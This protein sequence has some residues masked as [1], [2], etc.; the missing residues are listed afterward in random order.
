MIFSYFFQF[1]GLSCKICQRVW[2]SK[3]RSYQC[4]YNNE[5]F[6]WLLGS[7]QWLHGMIHSKDSVFLILHCETHSNHI[8]VVAFNVPQLTQPLFLQ[9]NQTLRNAFL[10]SIML[11][12]HRFSLKLIIS[13][14][15]YFCCQNWDQWHK[16]NEKN[17][18]KHSYIYFLLL[19][20]K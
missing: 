19:V 12:W 11:R 7:S 15:Y 18:K 14:F 16:L 2:L 17:P 5:Y 8:M 6:H 9:T 13:F 20:Q 4:N 1:Q 10:I 3:V